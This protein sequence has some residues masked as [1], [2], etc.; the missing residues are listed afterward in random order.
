MKIYRTCIHIGQDTNIECFLGHWDWIP[1]G[2]A[3]TADRKC[4]LE[5]YV[6]L[7][8]AI[9]MLTYFLLSRRPTL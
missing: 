5:D 6:V 8:H 1:N 4:F 2:K 3:A 9:A 7:V